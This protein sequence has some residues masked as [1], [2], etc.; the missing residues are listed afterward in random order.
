[1]WRGVL[2]IDEVKVV[3]K[4]DWD[5]ICQIHVR[6]GSKCTQRTDTF[7]SKD[8]AIEFMCLLAADLCSGKI[9]LENLKMEK[10]TR[11]TACGVPLQAPSKRKEKEAII[12]QNKEAAA[13][14]AGPKEPEKLGKRDKMLKRPAEAD[15]ETAAGRG[16]GRGN[17]RGRG[18]GRGRG[19]KTSPKESA[20]KDDSDSDVMGSNDDTEIDEEEEEEEHEVDEPEELDEKLT[21]RARTK[22]TPPNVVRWKALVKVDKWAGSVAEGLDESVGDKKKD[23]QSVAHESGGDYKVEEGTTFFHQQDSE[24]EVEGKQDEQEFEDDQDEQEVVQNIEDDEDMSPTMDERVRMFCSGTVCIKKNFFAALWLYVVVSVLH[25]TGYV[26]LTIIGSGSAHASRG[27]CSMAFASKKIKRQDSESSYSYSDSYSYSSETVEVKKEQPIYEQPLPR[28]F[29]PV[30]PPYPLTQP[31]LDVPHSDVRSIQ[32]CLAAWVPPAGFP[33]NVSIDIQ[34]MTKE[35]IMVGAEDG[36]HAMFKLVS[37]LQKRGTVSVEEPPAPPKTK[38]D[39]IIDDFDLVLNSGRCIAQNKMWQRVKKDMTEE[40]Q[41][42]YKKIEQMPAGQK[43]A[44]MEKYRLYF[45][46]MKKDETEVIRE[47]KKTVS[48]IDVTIGCHYPFE[49]IVKKEGGFRSKSAIK[50]AITRVMK[51]IVMGPPFVEFNEMSERVEFLF[52]RKKKL[53]V[54]DKSWEERQ[55]LL[56][57]VG[58]NGVHT[59]E[60]NG[61][62]VNVSM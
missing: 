1:M 31:P 45:I 5:P 16:N 6:G 33:S 9:Q 37:E 27:V 61:E 49:I 28:S 59:R 43:Q 62:S 35:G 42:A 52:V 2:G 47:S 60:V 50:A 3:D 29:T 20:V 46:K 39:R 10:N 40:Q 44:E 41:A 7:P 58:S 18:R 22:T 12:K 34:D 48:K 11:L 8:K 14:A 15:S 38:I 30:T 17:G 54:F 23:D 19:S 21:K 13:A 55:K 51:C 25:V 36:S 32:S 24:E 4:P 57:A 26:V 56:P 53:D